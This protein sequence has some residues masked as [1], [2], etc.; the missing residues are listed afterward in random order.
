MSKTGISLFLA[1]GLFFV[2]FIFFSCETVFSAYPENGLVLHLSADQ[3]VETDEQGKVVRWSDRT[4]EKNVA[5]PVAGKPAPVFIN[6]DRA[7]AF[8]SG[9]SLLLEK[10]VLSRDARQCSVFAA[11]R[12]ISGRSVPLLGSRHGATPLL[13][14][15]VDEYDAARFIV[16]NDKNQTL[17]ATVPAVLEA[18]TVFGGVLRDGSEEMSISVYF[19]MEESRTVKGKRLE[20]PLFSDR[21]L[22]GGFNLPGLPQH[23][24]N[25]DISEILVYDRALSDTEVDQVREYLL[26]KHRL[27]RKIE[28]KIHEDTWNTLSQTPYDGPIAEERRCDVCIIGAGSSGSAAAILSGREGA[29]TILVERQTLLGGSGTNALVSGWE[30]GPGC[31]LVR[32]LFDRM[33]AIDGA[34]VGRR[35]GI[36]GADF[37]YGLFLI[38]DEPYEYSTHRTNVPDKLFRDVPYKPEAF[39]RVVRDL[40]RETGRVRI[41][42]GTTFF[43]SETND[44]KDRIESIL[45]RQ[46]DGG[47]LRIR[48]RVFI[49]ATGDAWLCRS[50]GCE[51]MLGIDSKAMFDEPSAPSEPQ[52]RLNAVTRCYEITKRPGAK[53]APAP[54]RPV[55]FP[56]C[57]HIC[58][59]KDGPLTV[60]MLPTFEGQVLV[61][62]GYDETLRRSEEIV[63]AHWHW[64]QQYEY[65]QEYELVR[66]APMLGIREG[67]RVKTKYVLNE[68]DLIDTLKNQK[69][70]DMIAIADH[71]C[72]I[73]GAGG[74]LR[75]LTWAYGIPYRCL[76]P[77]GNCGN[78]LVACRGA[79][80]SRIAASSCRLQ[81]TMIQ[82]GHAA[83]IAAAEAARDDKS[84]DRV[85]SKA[86]A[87]RLNVSARYDEYI[88]PKN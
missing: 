70:E 51:T 53:R 82:I 85:D 72:D 47:V 81:R 33:K 10:P 61:N 13:Q 86:L 63:H 68:H 43:Q 40:C 25:G 71:P 56:K 18:Q 69:H 26:E 37:A 48:A 2:V 4:S 73:H 42:D 9:M 65:F 6:A 35:F 15:D 49:D 14:L 87:K 60:N 5:R 17:S 3:G 21:W 80:F 12:S 67:F 7:I 23:A 22:I 34:G 50:L 78:L 20:G 41:M 84:V 83:G 59:W 36:P 1:I 46:S 57:A 8:S 58:G 77:E 19:G 45:V 32:E 29:D 30:P 66:I 76:I 62:W 55:S 28:R 79:G 64:M 74:G 75:H 52:L 24:W 27:P 39:D 44:K 11:A 31:S 88:V 16:R 54:S 38:T